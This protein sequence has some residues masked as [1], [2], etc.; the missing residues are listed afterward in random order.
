M[1]LSSLQW[2]NS[3]VTSFAVSVYSIASTSIVFPSTTGYCAVGAVTIE[4]STF[5][6]PVELIP[7]KLFVNV[8]LHILRK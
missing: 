1:L 2:E 4:P 5:I 7:L 3:Y 8:R 6:E